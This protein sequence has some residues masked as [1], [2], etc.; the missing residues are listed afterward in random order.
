MPYLYLLDNNGHYGIL[1]LNVSGSVTLTSLLKEWGYCKVKESPVHLLVGLIK[2]KI[3]KRTF[4]AGTLL[5]NAEVTLE[6]QDTNYN[7][8]SYKVYVG[9]QFTGVLRIDFCHLSDLNKIRGTVPDD[10]IRLYQDIILDTYEN[11]EEAEES[12]LTLLN[13]LKGLCP[14]HRITSKVPYLSSKG[15]IENV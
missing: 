7:S 9:K 14:N 10:I 3:K 8:L 1:T 12:Y 11:K 5:V 4:R 2:N 15:Y 13:A 6:L